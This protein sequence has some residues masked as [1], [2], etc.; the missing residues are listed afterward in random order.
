MDILLD[1]CALIW[2]CSDPE[3][4]TPEAGK[5]LQK[6]ETNLFISDATVL[7]VA[8]KHS[9]GKLVLPTPPSDWFKEQCLLW[10]I[11]ALPISRDDIFLCAQLPPHHKDPFDRLIIAAARNR[12]LPIITADRIFSTYDVEVIW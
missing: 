2:L 5:I 11:E 10:T 9:A 7:E 12:N 1:T 4:L 3:R 8:L 6:E